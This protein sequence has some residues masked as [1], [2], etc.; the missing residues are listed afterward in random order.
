MFQATQ[1]VIKNVVL[2]VLASTQKLRLL[3]EAALVQE[4]PP[5]PELLQV[6][7]AELAYLTHEGLFISDA[8]NEAQQGVQ[9]QSSVGGARLQDQSLVGGAR[10][11]DQS[12]VVGA[13]LQDQSSVGGARLQQRDSASGYTETSVSREQSYM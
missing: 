8:L 13:R 5:G 9:D 6:G 7:G 2:E 11:Q 1:T 4:A 3:E 10:L 12:S